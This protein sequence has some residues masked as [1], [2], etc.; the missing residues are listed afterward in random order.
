MCYLTKTCH[1][2]LMYLV[3]NYIN[4]DIIIYLELKTSS[5]P[6]KLSILRLT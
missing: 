5:S 6:L 2:T 3:V 1:F 4:E